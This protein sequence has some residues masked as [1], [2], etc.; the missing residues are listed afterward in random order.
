MKINDSRLVLPACPD[1]RG[2]QIAHNKEHQRCIT[3]DPALKAVIEACDRAISQEDYDTLMSYYAEDAALVVKPGMVV[4]GKENIRKAFIAI[5]DYF[6][7]RLVVT[8]GKMEVIE[9]GGNA[10]VIMETR[11]DIPTADGISQVT[12]R[13]TYVFQKQGE[14]WLC[15][16]D[17]S[18]GTDLLDD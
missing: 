17:N 18:Y 5:A 4:R 8:Q 12:R 3:P 9:G 15:T 16:V 7:H 6:Q 11:L 14:R 2:G 13:A 1:R 10:L